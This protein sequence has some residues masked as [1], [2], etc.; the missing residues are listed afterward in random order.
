MY[1]KQ[2]AVAIKTAFWTAFGQYMKPVPSAFSEK[3]NWVNYHTG[4]KHVFFRMHANSQTAGIAIAIEH[5][6]SL[7]RQQLFQQF[8]TLRDLLET[9]TQEAWHWQQAH[10]NGYGKQIASI[11]CTL[12]AVNIFRE[13]DWPAIIAFLKPRLIALD[14]F[15]ADAKEI[16]ALGLNP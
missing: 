6:D 11:G 8:V 4:V 13:Q 5:P 9:Q 3:V 1:S 7:M 10:L 2:E 14:A 12:D 15:W 16:V